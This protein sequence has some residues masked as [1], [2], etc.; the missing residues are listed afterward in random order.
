MVLLADIPSLGVG[1]LE[2][3]EARELYG[4]EKE[5]DLLLPKESWYRAKGLACSSDQI[6]ITW[7]STCGLPHKFHGRY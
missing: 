4:Q 7:T 3:R 2:N 1:R 5:K 6:C